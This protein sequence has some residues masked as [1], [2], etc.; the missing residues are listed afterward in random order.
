MLGDVYIIK[1]NLWII[2]VVRYYYVDLI[3]RLLLSTHL[4]QD[5]LQFRFLFLN[6]I[7]PELLLQN[8]WR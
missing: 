2:F 5:H 3:Y 8:K 7:R 1:I 4:F 6:K